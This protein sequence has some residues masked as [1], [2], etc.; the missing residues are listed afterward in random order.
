MSRTVFILGAGASAQAGAPLMWN[1]LEVAERLRY[2]AGAAAEQDFEL[3]LKARAELQA[4]HSKAR[5]DIENLESV[6]AAFE[7]AALRGALGRLTDGQ[8]MRLPAAMRLLIVHTLEMAVRWTVTL[9]GQIHSPAPYHEFAALVRGMIQN[10]VVPRARPHD[11]SVITFN[12]DVAADYA[13]RRELSALG[14]SLDYCLDDPPAAETRQ[15]RLDFMK[16]HGSLNWGRCQEETCEG[17]YL[18]DVFDF[19]EETRAFRYT[20]GD[21]QPERIPLRI[22]E[23]GVVGLRCPRSN[24]PCIGQ[25]LIVPP[26]WS[27]TQHYQ[28]IAKVWKRAAQHLSEA[29]RIV[30]VGYSLTPADQSFA[31]LYGLGTVGDTWLKGFVVVDSSSLKASQRAAFEDR[32]RALLG[33]AVVPSRFRIEF[34]SFEW[35]IRANLLPD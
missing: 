5:L 7:M 34:E 8:V 11:V 21:G 14:I 30:V 31:Y 9:D 33:P 24:Q 1:F 25:P 12:Y 32:Y 3:V 13:L 19:A 17:V 28:R 15:T 29:E 2:E 6:F 26:T 18:R 4:V 10:Y 22:F 20:R 23:H 35:A 16:L 27:K